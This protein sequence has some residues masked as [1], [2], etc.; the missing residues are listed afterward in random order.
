M[1]TTVTTL[2]ACCVVLCLLRSLQNDILLGQ[3][4]QC[5]GMIGEAV[6]RA[7]FRTDGLDMMRTLMVRMVI[8]RDIAV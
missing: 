7:R 2:L 4:M 1:R 5:A 8:C 6:G 3:A